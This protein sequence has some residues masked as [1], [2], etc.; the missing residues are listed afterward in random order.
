LQYNSAD[1]DG[2]WYDPVM[3]RWISQDPIGIF[4]GDYN[5]TRYMGNA[6]TNFVGPSGLDPYAGGGYNSLNW[7]RWA[8]TGDASAPEYAYN[9]A[10][11][12]AGRS[13]TSNAGMAHQSLESLDNLAP[14]TRSQ[15]RNVRWQKFET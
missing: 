8:Y 3:S 9:A 13:Y 10:Q 7:M 2:R 15:S 14:T 12:G 11:N 1:G 6:P 5:F 4:G